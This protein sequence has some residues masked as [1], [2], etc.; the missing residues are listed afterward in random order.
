MFALPGLLHQSSLWR[1][2]GGAV[3][4][5]PQVTPKFSTPGSRKGQKGKQGCG[6]L[7]GA[8]SF[9]VTCSTSWHAFVLSVS[10]LCSNG[11][12]SVLS[13]PLPS[14]SPPG[15]HCGESGLAGEGQASQDGVRGLL[16]SSF[17]AASPR[18]L[19]K[20]EMMGGQ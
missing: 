19:A 15:G 4:K 12:P 5:V 16:C 2:S 6:T 11:S 8:V 14:L 18:L 10:P 9:K 17:L 3:F 20:I 13:R 1:P 7:E